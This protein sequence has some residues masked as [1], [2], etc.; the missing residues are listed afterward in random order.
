M[1]E[2]VF[3][4]TCTALVTPFDKNGAIAYDTLAQQIEFQLANGIDALCI[5]GTTG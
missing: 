2:P 3:T 5:C 4:G 1:R